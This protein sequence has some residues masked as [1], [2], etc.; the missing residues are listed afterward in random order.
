M[1]LHTGLLEVLLVQPLQPYYHVIGFLKAYR[2]SFYFSCIAHPNRDGGYQLASLRTLFHHEACS[3][4][5]L[6]AIKCNSMT[7][8]CKK[9]PCT[10]GVGEVQHV[11]NKVS[12]VRLLLRRCK[13]TWTSLSLDP[14]LKGIMVSMCSWRRRYLLLNFPHSCFS[15]Q[16]SFLKDFLLFPHLFSRGGG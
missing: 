4:R 7:M 8:F 14:H 12:T 2:P 16:L 13:I 6:A 15:L 3:N 10:P 11:K 9:D 1:K 5:A